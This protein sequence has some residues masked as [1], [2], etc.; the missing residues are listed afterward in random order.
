MY[1]RESTLYGRF[2]WSCVGSPP[3]RLDEEDVYV[4]HS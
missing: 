1:R 3:L 4:D 2:E